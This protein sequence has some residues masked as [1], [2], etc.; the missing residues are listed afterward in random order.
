MYQSK[1]EG[2]SMKNQQ[3][4]LNNIDLVKSFALENLKAFRTKK[5]HNRR[6]V[7]NLIKTIETIDEKAFSSQEKEEVI[8]KIVT[9]IKL[10]RQAMASSGETSRR[11]S[12][13]FSTLKIQIENR[14]RFEMLGVSKIFPEVV[15]ETVKYSRGR[16]PK[17][18]LNTIDFSNL[19]ILYVSGGKYNPYGHALLR[20]GDKGYLHINNRHD[21][22]EYIPDKEHLI[23][24]LA[25]KSGFLVK[26]EAYV[27]GEQRLNIRSPEEA[28]KM[29]RQL[30]EQKWLWLVAHHNCLSFAQTVAAAGG[31]PYSEL[32]A[33]HRTAKLPVEFMTQRNGTSGHVNSLFFNSKLYDGLKSI[34][35]RPNLYE[36]SYFKYYKEKLIEKSEHP[37]VAGLC[38]SLIVYAGMKKYEAL[39]LAKKT[40]VARLDH[41]TK[42][43]VNVE[44]R[45][46][47]LIGFF[48]GLKAAAYTLGQ[49]SR[50]ITNKM[51]GG[52]I[53]KE[54]LSLKSL[55]P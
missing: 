42:R 47:R 1:K 7:L 24:Y 28:K 16:M 39:W 43:K 44:R 9:Y 11:L 18:V 48:H 29:I 15:S 13:L 17:E 19:S 36:E 8:E 27:L 12:W 21:Y 3:N 23:A 52:K 45:K 37:D 51:S 10:A 50:N 22:P 49:E 46:T 4:K 41:K 40:Y 33:T 34:S 25:K 30:T 54:R 35:N 14:E 2:G 6:I 32:G 5:T 31:I 38:A 55:R 53:G 26:E 20:L